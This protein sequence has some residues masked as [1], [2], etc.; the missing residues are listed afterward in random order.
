[1]RKKKKNTKA[2]RQLGTSNKAHGIRTPGATAARVS[3]TPLHHTR[4]QRV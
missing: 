2:E 4:L 1:L 3:P